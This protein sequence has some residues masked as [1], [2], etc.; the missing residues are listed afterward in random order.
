MDKFSLREVL[1]AL[2]QILNK[3]IGDK[4][5]IRLW[6]ENG[7]PD[8]YLGNPSVLTQPLKTISAFMAMNLVNGIISL[9]LKQGSKLKNNITL[10]VNI[11]GSGISESKFSSQIKSEEQLIQE[12]EVLGLRTNHELYFSTNNKTLN[13]TLKIKLVVGSENTSPDF[14]DKKVLIVEDNEVNAL[15]FSNFLEDWGV[16]VSLAHN[17]QEGVE[18]AFNNEYHA[19]IMDIYMPVLNGIDAIK[20]IRQFNE[21]IPIIGLSASSLTQDRQNAFDA[22]VNEYLSKPISSDKLLITL[23]KLLTE[24]H[25]SLSAN[26]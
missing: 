11:T 23:S 24:S 19:I 21:K 15:V 2:I 17:G 13:A 14:H 18:M 20:K 25:M 6:V 8:W 26:R 3:N 4:N 5:I 9:E 10:D 7:I 1:N 22:G 12:F 16:I